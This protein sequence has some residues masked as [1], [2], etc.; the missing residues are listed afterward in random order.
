MKIPRSI[1]YCVIVVAISICSYN[2]SK[3]GSNPT[4]Y[5]TTKLEEA[6]NSA[7]NLTNLNALIVARD[8]QI[9][10]EV[11][12]N[13]SGPGVPHDVRSVT[14]SV[15]ALLYGKAISKGAIPSITTSVRDFLFPLSSAYQEYFNSI[16]IG[17]LLSMSSGIDWY[18]S[19]GVGYNTWASASNQ[20]DYVLHCAKAAESGTTFNYNSGAFHLLSVILSQASKQSTFSF[21]QE[22]LFIP[23]EID[24]PD[25]ETDNQ[26]YENG[27]AGLKI[28]P[29]DM[30]KIGELILHNGEYNGKSIIPSTWI[31][32]L[33]ISRINPN[34]Y[35][36][37]ASGYSYG[38]WTGTCSK[39]DYILAN[40]FGGQFIVIVPSI[41]LVVVATNIWKGVSSVNANDQWYRTLDLILNH[42][43]DSFN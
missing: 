6:F 28:T 12:Y 30:L 33:K 24:T 16:T 22:N 35:I 15:I 20:V 40:G 9:I 29:R 31:Q 7:R 14:K 25:W 2:C 17:S 13:N 27:S 23:M 21:A 18:E 1:V 37:F 39:G 26:G 10:K 38:W 43:C 3:S 32:H 8:T 5:N 34:N 19:G 36:P 11:Y 42:I 4:V 41:Q